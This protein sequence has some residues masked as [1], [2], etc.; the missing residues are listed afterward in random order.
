MSTTLPKRH[1]AVCLRNISVIL[2]SHTLCLYSSLYLRTIAIMLV[3]SF[4]CFVT[5]YIPIA[6]CALAASHPFFHSP[7]LVGKLT[8]RQAPGSV[9]ASQFVRRAFQGCKCCCHLISIDPIVTYHRQLLLLETGSILTEVKFPTIAEGS[10]MSTVSVKP[11]AE[12]DPPVDEMGVSNN[13]A[14]C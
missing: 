12:L 6:T 11:H 1:C 5:V 13:T 3:S 8:S 4:L 14:F 2:S 10:N 9:P 7:S